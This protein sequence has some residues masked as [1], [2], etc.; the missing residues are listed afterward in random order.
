[1]PHAQDIPEYDIVFLR[2]NIGTSNPLITNERAQVKTSAFVPFGI[3]T[4]AGQR[5]KGHCL[6]ALQLCLA[7]L[8]MAAILTLWHGV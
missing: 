4:E 1:L 7:I 3:Q 5:I 6:A 8:L 2:V